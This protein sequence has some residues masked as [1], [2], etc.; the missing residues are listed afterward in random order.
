MK[1]EYYACDMCDKRIV[2]DSLELVAMTVNTGE[3]VERVHP[4]FGTKLGAEPAGKS[5][6][7][8]SPECA[9]TFLMTR[10]AAAA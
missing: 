6:L 10:V 5:V 4:L 7:A 8:C 9:I 2:E 1:V 3:M